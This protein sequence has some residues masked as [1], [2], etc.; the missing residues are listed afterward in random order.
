MVLGRKRTY[1]ASVLSV[2]VANGVLRMHFFLGNAN[3]RPLIHE[4][5]YVCLSFIV[6]DLGFIRVS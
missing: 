1:V 6:L 2:L 5:L 3:R 4:K